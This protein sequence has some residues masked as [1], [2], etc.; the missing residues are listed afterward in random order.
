MYLALHYFPD[1]A[2]ISHEHF[3]F[4][5]TAYKKPAEY[6]YKSTLKI[7]PSYTAICISIFQDTGL[8][9]VKPSFHKS[10]S[11]KSKRIIGSDNS[12][13]REIKTAD[14]QVV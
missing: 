9:F 5:A 2:S 4:T 10:T 6:S 3:I 1:N 14:A 12:I 11:T 13:L 7:L 8:M